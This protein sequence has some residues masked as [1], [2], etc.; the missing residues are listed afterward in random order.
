MN[1]STRTER[2]SDYDRIG[3]ALVYLEQNRGRAVPLAD[4]ARA[5][6]LSKF[7]FQ[8]LFTRWT[9]ISPKRFARYLSA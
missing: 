9:G 7:H 1:A 4:L 2:S 6:G 3:A 5:V 8:R